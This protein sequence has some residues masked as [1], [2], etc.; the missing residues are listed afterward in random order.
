MGPLH[1]DSCELTAKT[2][3]PVQR[4]QLMGGSDMSIANLPSAIL[5]LISVFL[6][7][8]MAGMR[9]G[10]WLFVVGIK[11]VAI[12][13]LIAAAV[14]WYA[15]NARAQTIPPC[16]AAPNV[17]DKLYATPDPCMY[18]GQT[19]PHLIS[20]SKQYSLNCGPYNCEKMIRIYLKT[21]R[22][23]APIER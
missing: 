9:A 22:V 7:L 2:L 8:A 20:Q 18:E 16:E 12:L 11:S 13:A 5:G 14:A 4:Y 1:P 15:S 6:G 3:T 17:T 10:Y 19:G 23:P 21:K